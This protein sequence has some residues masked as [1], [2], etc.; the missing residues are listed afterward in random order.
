[1]EK[2]IERLVNGNIK[3]TCEIQLLGNV[4]IKTE[5]SQTQSLKCGHCGGAMMPTYTSRAVKDTFIICVARMPNGALQN[6][7][8]IK[9][10]QR[11]LS[12]S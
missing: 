7:P 5:R 6:V 11:M 8:F 10:R 2:T 3:V 9:Y 12:G 1:M 4:Q